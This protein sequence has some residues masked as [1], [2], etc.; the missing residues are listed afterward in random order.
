[1]EETG[2]W[3]ISLNSPTSSRVY[4]TTSSKVNRSRRG[5]HN[6]TCSANELTGTA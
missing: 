3:Y 6:L 1:M 5:A 4:D 2:Q